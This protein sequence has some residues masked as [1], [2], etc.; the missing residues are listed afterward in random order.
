MPE[1]N[2]VVAVRVCYSVSPKFFL[3]SSYVLGNCQDRVAYHTK[4]L[5]ATVTKRSQFLL[6]RALAQ[7]YARKDFLPLVKANWIEARSLPPFGKTA[8]RAQNRSQ[9]FT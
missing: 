3:Y 1:D 8:S 5:A 9:R 6:G 2:T 4:Q 7:I